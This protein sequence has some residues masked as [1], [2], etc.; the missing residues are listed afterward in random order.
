MNAN[1]ED[2]KDVLQAFPSFALNDSGSAV[3]HTDKAAAVT[4]I[5]GL[6]IQ[7][8]EQDL[9]EK[10]H[11]C[12]FDQPMFSNGLYTEKFK[13]KTCNDVNDILIAFAFVSRAIIY[14]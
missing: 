3:R 13:L 2:L 11:T 12:A 14:Q 9:P 5:L 1:T 4:T 8:E 7:S 6:C 10:I